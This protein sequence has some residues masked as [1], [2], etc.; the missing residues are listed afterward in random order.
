MCS[1][2]VVPNC[3]FSLC[4]ARNYAGQV[5]VALKL[6]HFCV[7]SYSNVTALHTLGIGLILGTINCKFCDLSRN[8]ST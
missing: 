7:G 8:R 1:Y 2:R 6:A 3:Y 5:A 4:D